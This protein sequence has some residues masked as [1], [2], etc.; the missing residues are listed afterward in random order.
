MIIWTERMLWKSY[1]R[2][3]VDYRAESFLVRTVFLQMPRLSTDVA[4]FLGLN[5]S[6]L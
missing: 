5:S 1:L 4:T 6:V 3:H 2:Q